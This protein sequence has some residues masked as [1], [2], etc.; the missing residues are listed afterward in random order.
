MSYKRPAL[1][2][3]R[4][5][6]INFTRAM[7]GVGMNFASE[8]DYSADIEVTLLHASLLGMEEH[9]LRVLSVLST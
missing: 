2:S 8:A 7:A 3:A 1:L 5:D 6:D 9:D 4:P